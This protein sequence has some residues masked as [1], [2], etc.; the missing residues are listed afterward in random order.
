MQKILKF[1]VQGLNYP[2]QKNLRHIILHQIKTLSSNIEDKIKILKEDVR[3]HT[4]ENGH[5]EEPNLKSMIKNIRETKPTVASTYFKIDDNNNKD[6]IEENSNDNSIQDSLSAIR[7]TIK[8][9]K[10]EEMFP[11][12][13]VNVSSKIDINQYNSKD[14]PSTELTLIQNSLQKSAAY[15][16]RNSDLYDKFNKFKLASLMLSDVPGPKPL[17]TYAKIWNL[18][19]FVGNQL[20][21]VLHKGIFHSIENTFQD[22]LKIKPSEYFFKKYGTIVHFPGI[23]GGNLIMLNRPEHMEI[24]FLQEDKLIQCSYID[25]LEKYRQQFPQFNINQ[26][27]NEISSELKKNTIL[28]AIENPSESIFNRLELCSDE[29][30]TKISQIKNQRDEIPNDFWNEIRKWSLECAGHYLFSKR[31]GFFESLREVIPKFE[32]IQLHDGLDNITQAI[33]RCEKGLQFWRIINTPSWMKLLN[34]MKIIDRITSQY[35]LKAQK[36]IQ[37]MQCNSNATENSEALPVIENLLISESYDFNKVK[38]IL[39]DMLI[40]GRN[41]VRIGINFIYF[42]FHIIISWFFNVFFFRYQL[43][44]HLHYII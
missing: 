35:I 9:K 15:A 22:Q 4:N 3:E 7:K 25:C 13:E 42:L 19:P 17:K 31:F 1:N 38:T 10:K 16:Q 18:I 41:S 28:S 39:A 5:K 37:E 8:I 34:N 36:N 29:I 44:L 32:A 6:S 43:H 40:L 23:F 21:I 30:I 11:Y 24:V 2:G 27:F 33:E 14:E 12:Y 26:K 20:S